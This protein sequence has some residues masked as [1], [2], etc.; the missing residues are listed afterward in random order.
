MVSVTEKPNEKSVVAVKTESG[1]EAVPAGVKPRGLSGL[2][3]VVAAVPAAAGVAA[4]ALYDVVYNPFGQHV[5]TT[6]TTTVPEVAKMVPGQEVNLGDGYSLT[7]IAINNGYDMVKVTNQTGAVV[8]DLAVP[9]VTGG[10]NTVFTLPNGQTLILTYGGSNANDTVTTLKFSLQN[11]MQHL[12]PNVD[13]HLAWAITAI[14]I[15]GG[16]VLSFLT[17]MRLKRKPSTSEK[18]G[19]HQVA[20]S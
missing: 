10:T 4:A 15:G 18:T 16:A 19:D 12:V 14:L 3:K 1:T 6:V 20:A 7:L 17:Y 8:A 9:D 2:K 13:P 11:T 5:S